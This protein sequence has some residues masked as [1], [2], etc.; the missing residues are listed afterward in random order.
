MST[1]LYSLEPKCEVET[2]VHRSHPFASDEGKKHQVMSQTTF[3]GEPTN[4]IVTNYS[5]ALFIMI[6]QV[7]ILLLRRPGSCYETM[8]NLLTPSPR[9]ARLTFSLYSL[10]LFRFSVF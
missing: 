1:Q 10:S 9:L 2:G 3:E 5:N 6:T 7:C 8:S 4:I